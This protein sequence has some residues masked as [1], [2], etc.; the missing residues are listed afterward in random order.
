[1][2]DVVLA[3][4][5]D[6]LGW[7]PRSARSV[8]VAAGPLAVLGYLAGSV[9]FGYLLS[10]RRLRRQ[11]EDPR[12]GRLPAP[13]HR[14][15]G[16]DPLDA[17]GVLGAAALAALTTLVATTVAWDV[18]VAASPGARDFAAIGIFSDQALG[19]WV[20]VA[21]WTGA[22]AV[23]GHVA[24]VWS[25]FR[26]GTGV[27]PALALALAY[28]PTVFAVA[29]GTF[30][31]VYGLRRSPQIALLGAVPAALVFSYLAWLGDLQGGWGITNGPESTLWVAAVGGVLF[32]RNLREPDASGGEGSQ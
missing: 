17:P 28:V 14:G 16:D 27:P 20:S 26:G 4:V 10:R 22:A 31:A 7:V 3:L 9:P 6:L 11:M 2:P 24:P 13:R 23:V 15:G 32:A 30:L 1:V 25:G 5:G 18:A 21:L 12:L 29:A 8:S 19:A